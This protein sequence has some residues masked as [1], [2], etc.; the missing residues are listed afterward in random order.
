MEGGRIVSKRKTVIAVAMCAV[1]LLVMLASSAYIAR[2][3]AHR[4][5][6]AGEKC[7]IC[8]FIAQV[9]QLRRSLAGALL[10]LLALRLVTATGRA[11]CPRLAV[12]TPVTCT[13]V[14]RKIRL[15]D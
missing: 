7:P 8:Q 14:G 4:H 3:T 9:A 13:L 5:D 6:C 2:E 1:M 15:N 12:A 11:R 10:A